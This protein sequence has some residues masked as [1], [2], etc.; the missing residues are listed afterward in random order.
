MDDL[1]QT[2]FEKVKNCHKEGSNSGQ[3]DASLASDHY[4]NQI[5]I[6]TCKFD[7]A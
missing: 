3:K 7:T 2:L 4:A 1:S 5:T 6:T